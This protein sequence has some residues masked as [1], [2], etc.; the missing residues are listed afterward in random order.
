VI[1]VVVGANKKKAAHV[2]TPAPAPASAPTRPEIDQAAPQAPVADVK[3]PSFCPSCG[4]PV[5][6]DEKFCDKCGQKLE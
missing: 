4:D 5:S 6:P 3:K 2:A 1:L